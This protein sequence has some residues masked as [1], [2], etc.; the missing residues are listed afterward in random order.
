MF[1]DDEELLVKLG[2][3]MLERL[4]YRVAGFTNSEEALEMFKN[5]KDAYDLII[6]D[7][8]M[9]K[10]T[11]LDLAA[12][13]KKVRPDIPILLCTGFLDK[14]IDD[15][16]QKAGITEYVTKPLNRQEMAVA[17]RRV[18]DKRIT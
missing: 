2:T 9:P 12:G 18:L 5:A 6:T 16:V 17:V 7:K 13:I 14:D 15:K 8:T 10:M 3:K 11:G 1:V 4:G